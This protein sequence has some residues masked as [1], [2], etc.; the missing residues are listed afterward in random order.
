MRNFWVVNDKGDHGNIIA[1]N[2]HQAE[3]M[4]FTGILKD[5]YPIDAII[6]EELVADSQIQIIEELGDD[7]IIFI[8]K[9]K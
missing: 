6:I 7:D 3:K 9:K 2:E 5:E 1:D 4:L 8:E